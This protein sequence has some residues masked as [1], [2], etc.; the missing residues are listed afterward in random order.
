M[1]EKMDTPFD[2]WSPAHCLLSLLITLIGLIK[3]IF[4]D[5]LQ[6]LYK[7]LYEQ[8]FPIA[9]SPHLMQSFIPFKLL[10][11]LLILLFIIL[12]FRLI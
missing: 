7:I 5:N 11:T 4:K 12:S 8:I 2:K 9:F 3:F 6:T 10:V 1:I